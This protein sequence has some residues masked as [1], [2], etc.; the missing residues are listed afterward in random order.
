MAAVLAKGETLIQNA[1][2]EPEV[3][4]LCNCLTSM[5]AKIDG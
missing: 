1:A 2:K 5:G 3:E 4:D